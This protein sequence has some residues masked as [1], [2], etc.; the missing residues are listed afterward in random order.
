MSS[1][2]QEKIISVNNAN[3]IAIVGFLPLG[4]PTPTIFK[5]LIQISFKEGVDLIELGVPAEDSYLD[6]NVISNAYDRLRKESNLNLNSLVELGGRT[7]NLTNNIGFPIVYKETV[8]K[9]RPDHF[10]KMLQDANYQGVLIPNARFEQ[11]KLF[12]KL[13]TQHN[14]EFIGFV[15]ADYPKKE[16]DEIVD[17][18][19]GFIYMQGISG[20]TGQHIKIDQSLL[21]RYHDLK[22]LAKRKKLPVLIGFGVR[23]AEDVK[24]FSDI[25]VDGVIIGTSFVK[26]ASRSKR[27]F[28][29]YLRKIKGSAKKGMNV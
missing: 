2:I 23:D 25:Q 3:R 21:N 9:F 26:A 10:F 16:I 5:E 20:S 7:L 28:I 29:E 27:E 1:L 6:G 19:D 22:K 14:L 12:S 11:R 17:I 8:E 18:S 24:R 15:S 4:F 13:A